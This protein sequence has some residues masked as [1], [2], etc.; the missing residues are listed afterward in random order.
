MQWI[1]GL[2]K[3][4]HDGVGNEY[5]GAKTGGDGSVVKR[6]ALQ[7]DAQELELEQQPASQELI[8]ETQEALSEHE[9]EVQGALLYPQEEK[10][11]ASS[12]PEVEAQKVISEHKQDEAGPAAG[13]TDM[14]GPVVPAL[15][16]LTISGILPPIMSSRTRIRRVHTSVEGAALQSFLPTIKEVDEEGGE[17]SVSVCNGGGSMALEVKVVPKPIAGDMPPETEEEQQALDL[18][19]WKEWRKAEEV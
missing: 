16:N 14:E 5:L 2:D 3:T 12:D 6:R 4:G 11:E 13:L 10:Q 17:A 8:Q 7:L 18:P 19:E 15:R 1:D 9:H